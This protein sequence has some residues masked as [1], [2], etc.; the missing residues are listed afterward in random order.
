MRP[1]RRAVALCEEIAARAEDG[2]VVVIDDAHLLLG[3][4][5]ETELA[6]LARE[7]P[8]RASLRSPRDGRSSAPSG[9]PGPTR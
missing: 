6:A 4:R 3:S 5:G 8:A 7:L 1:E 2:V 9:A